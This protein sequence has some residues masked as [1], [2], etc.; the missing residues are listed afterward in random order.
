[1]LRNLVRVMDVKP[2]CEYVVRGVVS[3]D[4]MPFAPA[5][6]MAPVKE[7]ISATTLWSLLTCWDARQLSLSKTA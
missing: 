1:M 7:S 2:L 5:L 4:G 3:R 6:V